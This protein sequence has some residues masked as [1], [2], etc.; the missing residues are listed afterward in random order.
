MRFFLTGLTIVG[1]ASPLAAQWPPEV[2]NL[3]VIATD[4]KFNVLLDTMKAFTRAL[5]VRCSYCHVGREDQELA[6]YNFASDDKPAKVKAREMLKMVGA[7][8]DQYLAALP[9]RRQPAITVSCNTC[10]HGISQPRTVQQVVLG[11]YATGG[12]TAADST[13]RALRT[14]YYGAAAYDFGEVPLTDVAAAIQAQG[15][16]P[17]AV[18]FYQLNIQFLPASGFALRQLGFQYLAMHDTA[19]A[20]GTFKKQLELQ[21]NNTETKQ[22]VD[23]LSKKP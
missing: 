10:H 15:S 11:A 20:L 17:D 21:P 14:R 22:L 16:N 2:K 8:N 19:S 12:Y 3:K 23:R 7:I 18:R 4:T 6:D 5:G 13:Y 1:L 9:M